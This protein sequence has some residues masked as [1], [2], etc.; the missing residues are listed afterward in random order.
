MGAFLLPEIHAANI[1]DLARSRAWLRLLQY[2]SDLLPSRS[3][4]LNSEFFASENGS[5]DPLSEMQVLTSLFSDIDQKNIHRNE[6]WACVFPA[7][8][9]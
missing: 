3:V 4:A 8:G 6:P 5:S 7:P 9:K 1:D 2:R